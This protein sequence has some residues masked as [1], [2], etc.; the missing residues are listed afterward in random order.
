VVTSMRQA[1]GYTWVPSALQTPVE[2]APGLPAVGTNS[3]YNP[4][5]PPS[6]SIPV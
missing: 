4:N 2:D 1:E 5:N 6:G 3:A